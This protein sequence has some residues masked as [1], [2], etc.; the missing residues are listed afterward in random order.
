[1]RTQVA[2]G[3]G[4]FNT[5]Y[6]SRGYRE[7]LTEG[8][9]ARA[10][11]IMQA[12]LTRVD[13]GEDKDRLIDQ[14]FVLVNECPGK[15]ISPQG[16][17]RRIHVATHRAFAHNLQV[18]ADGYVVID[19]GTD[20]MAP[21]PTTLC[22]PDGDTVKPNILRLSKDALRRIKPSTDP[23]KGTALFYE[24]SKTPVF[25]VLPKEESLRHL[26]FQNKKQHN[27]VRTA[28][29]RIFKKFR[30]TCRGKGRLVVFDGKARST[31][32]VRDNYLTLGPKVNRSGPGVTSYSPHAKT[33]PQEHDAIQRV[34]AQMEQIA[35]KY[36][37]SDVVYG[38]AHAY[39]CAPW[40]RFRAKL[41]SKECNIF[42]G[43]TISSGSFHNVHVDEDFTLSVLSLLDPDYAYHE[44]D[45]STVVRYFCFPRLGIAM[46][47]RVGDIIIFNSQEYH[48]SSS[49]SVDR[50]VYGVTCFLK[51][52]HVG[53]NDNK[54]PLTKFQHEIHEFMQK[55]K[56]GK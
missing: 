25:M 12:M 42:A 14:S 38:I 16:K 2:S 30:Y 10:E 1:M 11:R 48:C 20:R 5:D 24:N 54:L 22:L 40:P 13:K 15:A 41:E 17:F 6:L 44:A 39:K 47:L 55:V 4:D 43:C 36:M 52:A 29:R 37:P 56:E 49:M 27:R 3:S 26:R 7:A 23:D 9:S 8:D 18:L 28:F 32:N 50:Q 19:G 51:S 45:D 31:G 46:G 53:A 34:A 33:L 21:L 35:I